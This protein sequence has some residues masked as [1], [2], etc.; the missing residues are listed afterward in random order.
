[1]KL[2]H[3]AFERVL[4]R[5]GEHLVKEL[6]TRKLIPDISNNNYYSLSEEESTYHYTF[7]P[8][9]VIVEVLHC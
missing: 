1:M 2:V 4:L 8:K 3:L 9:S 5:L 6:N 7:L